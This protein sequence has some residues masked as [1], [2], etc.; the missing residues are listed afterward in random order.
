METVYVYGRFLSQRV[1]GVQRFAIE[2]S[3]ELQ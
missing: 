2:I 1:T 3:K